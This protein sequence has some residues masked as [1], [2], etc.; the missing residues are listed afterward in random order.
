M[1]GRDFRETASAAD[2]REPRARAPVPAPTRPRKLL[3]STGGLNSS[4]IAL[5]SPGILERLLGPSPRL[6]RAH[7]RGV[8]DCCG[9]LTHPPPL[10]RLGA[11]IRR[12]FSGQPKLERNCH[13]TPCAV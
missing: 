2:G 12:T 9:T 6:F 8:T 1:F 3:R 5:Q 13:D 11:E 10:H 4:G 7:A